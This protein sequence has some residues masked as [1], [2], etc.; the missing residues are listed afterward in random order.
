MKCFPQVF[1]ET[2]APK[3]ARSSLS[4][5]PA[6]CRCLIIK[7]KALDNK[8]RSSLDRNS[9]FLDRLAGLAAD[10]VLCWGFA[11][12]ALLHGN[13]ATIGFTF[14]FCLMS[15]PSR[16]LGFAFRLLWYFYWQP[17][18]SS[19]PQR[20]LNLAQRPQVLG[21]ENC[22]FA[23]EMIASVLSM[24]KLFCMWRNARL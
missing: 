2:R 24:E 13:I 4:I 17:C 23:Q 15:L 1:F 8:R 22:L 6:I 3:N 21:F 16:L 14:G 19:M 7:I 10:L 9:I 5:A 18:L 20:N 11:T 12:G